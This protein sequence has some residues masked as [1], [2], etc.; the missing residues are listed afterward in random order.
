LKSDKNVADVKNDLSDVAAAVRAELE[1]L[2]VL[3]PATRRKWLVVLAAVGLLAAALKL[4][5]YLTT[6]K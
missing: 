6:V 3:E 1:K 5:Y 2:G 4:A